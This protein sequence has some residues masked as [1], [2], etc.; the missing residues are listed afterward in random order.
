[1]A[2]EGDPKFVIGPFGL[3][4]RNLSLSRAGAPVWTWQTRL[5]VLFILAQAAGEIV[6]KQEL[7]DKAWPGLIV[8]ENNLQVQIST[9]RKVLGDGYIVTVPGRGYQLLSSGGNASIGNP[10]DK[11]SIVVLPFVN[12]SGD[13]AQEYF[14]DGMSE[15]II[16]AL[17]RLQSLF[18]IAR[19]SSLVYRAKPLTSA[20]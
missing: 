17:S 9:L 5:M 8:E 7:L 2:V 4:E 18:V 16:T 13:A 3:D 19:N 12:M 14:A 20:R 10:A 15:E 6:G 1:M 11:P